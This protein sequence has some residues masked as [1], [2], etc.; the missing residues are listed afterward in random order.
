LQLR[1]VRIIEGRHEGNIVV[2]AGG[3]LTVDGTVTGTIRVL[4]GGAVKVRGYC[5][6]LEVEDGGLLLLSGAA[7]SLHVRAGGR[8]EV[9]G[10]VLGVSAI[11]SGADLHVKPHAHITNE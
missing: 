1:R 11:E 7:G 8:A 3:A 2:L 9:S 6:A 5:D 10:T 4:R